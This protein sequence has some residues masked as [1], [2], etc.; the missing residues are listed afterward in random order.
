MCNSVSQFLTQFHLEWK[1]LNLETSGAQDPHGFHCYHSRF[2]S[3]NICYFGFYCLLQ[4][5]RCALTQRV[6][7]ILHQS[8]VLFLV[9][10]YVSKVHL[11]HSVSK[12]LWHA[13]SSQPLIPFF[14][15][16]PLWRVWNVKYFWGVCPALYFPSTYSLILFCGG[17]IQEFHF[18]ASSLKSLAES[19]AEKL[20]YMSLLQLLQTFPLIWCFW[21][22]KQLK[23]IHNHVMF[24]QNNLFLGE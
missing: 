16:C 20:V 23:T 13:L 1:L 7:H 18:P 15:T 19:N 22:N 12:Y 24:C 4:S 10:I 5:C 8:H 6:C 14:L 3:A 21:T 2:D 9:A 11:L 17:N